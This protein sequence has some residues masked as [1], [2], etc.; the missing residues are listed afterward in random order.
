LVYADQV[1]LN[2]SFKMTSGARDVAV[3]ASDR[4]E[5]VA[6]ASLTVGG[7]RMPVMLFPSV[8]Q[9]RDAE[10]AR[11]GDGSATPPKNG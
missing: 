7:C 4:S 3:A 1:V 8:D 10:L 6:E 11:E 9:D 2:S 5:A